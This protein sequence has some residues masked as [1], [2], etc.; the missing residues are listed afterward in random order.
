MFETPAFDIESSNYNINPIVQSTPILCVCGSTVY[1]YLATYIKT[2]RRLWVGQYHLISPVGHGGNLS[3]FLPTWTGSGFDSFSSTVLG[4]HQVCV[5][6]QAVRLV[7]L[8]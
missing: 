1:M 2:C 8:W 4:K 3:Q 5:G 6:L 7:F